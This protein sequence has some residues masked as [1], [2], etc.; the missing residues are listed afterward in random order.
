[1]KRL[2]ST[3]VLSL[4]LLFFNIPSADAIFGI[5]DCSKASKSIKSIEK[6]VVSN[7]DYAEGLKIVRPKVDGA[8]GVKLYEKYS[9]I[10]SD[11]KK[12]RGI[13]S[14]NLKCFSVGTQ[15]YINDNRYW[16]ADYYV[17]LGPLMG[18]YVI[19]TGPEY[20]PLKFK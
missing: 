8:Q 18:R 9:R 7:I 13:A 20:L 1:M 6:S 14:S 3:I 10:S 12:I 5:G 11:L 17:Y 16:S 15:T 4:S 19:L 2:L